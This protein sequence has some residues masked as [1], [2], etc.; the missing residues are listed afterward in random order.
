MG[1]SGS[2][3]LSG[4]SSDVVAEVLAVWVINVSASVRWWEREKDTE[5]E[6]CQGLCAICLGLSDWW[7]CIWF[8]CDLT[9]AQC[10]IQIEQFCEVTGDSV[11]GG[12]V[13]R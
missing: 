1:G 10:L 7:Q 6:S 2:D 12:S 11:S 13:S 5:R 4:F 3:I 8:Q 9:V